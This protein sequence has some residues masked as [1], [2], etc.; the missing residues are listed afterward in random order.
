MRVLILLAIILIIGL[1]SVV[2]DIEE[3]LTRPIIGRCPSRF[4]ILTIPK[5]GT[6]CREI[7]TNVIEN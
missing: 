3:F 5:Y 1:S 6:I 7:Q 4:Y 2:G